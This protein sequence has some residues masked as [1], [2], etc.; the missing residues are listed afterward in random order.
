MS[1]VPHHFPFIGWDPCENSCPMIIGTYLRSCN[2]VLN[3]IVVSRDSSWES[4][5]CGIRE[6]IEVCVYM[7]VSYMYVRLKDAGSN[8]CVG[9]VVCSKLKHPMSTHLPSNEFLKLGTITVSG[10]MLS[11]L[12]W[13]I[14]SFSVMHTEMWEG[15]VREITWMTSQVDSR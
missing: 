11:P 15:L 14:G 6:G 2:V 10:C 1:S 5:G 9:R 8:I 13:I 3:Y 4:K 7:Y 12:Y